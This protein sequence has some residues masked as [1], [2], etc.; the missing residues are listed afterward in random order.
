[1]QGN[2]KALL[3]E[4]DFAIKAGADS[5]PHMYALKAEALMKLHRHQEANAALLAGL[6]FDDDDFIK[7]FGPIGNAIML[8]AQA[9]VDMAF[10]RLEFYG[11]PIRFCFN[12]VQIRSGSIHVY[13]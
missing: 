4:T 7:C 2:W 11:K 5:T 9:Q 10:G 3:K 12:F 1:M 13:F 8:V 6:K